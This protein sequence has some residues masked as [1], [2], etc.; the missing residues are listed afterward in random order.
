[1]KSQ[2]DIYR[3]SYQDSYPDIV[4][5]KEQIAAI[6]L[7]MEAMTDD[8]Y[9][10]ASSSKDSLENPLYEEL[11]KRQAEIDVD[12]MSLNR[13]LSSMEGM[14][15]SEYARS[16]RV[17]SHEADMSE[18]VRDYDV[19]REIYEEMLG[20]KEKAR[21][22]MTLDLEGQGVSFKI[23]E[24]AVYPL[25]PS[26]LRFIHFALAGPLAGLVAVLGLVAAYILL[27]PRVRSPILM[28]Q[29]LPA[30]IE[31]LATIP[32]INSSVVDRFKRSDMIILVVGFLLVGAAYA[33][34]TVSRLLGVL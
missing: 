16:E 24:P 28:V 14:L 30:N 15:K 1:M 11:R 23:Q 19:T 22:S 3:L 26:G 8:G 21:L 13:R 12:L 25:E 18:L 2:L 20:R 17:A 33:A 6:E 31:L 9:F 32:H 7:V 27:D 34:L 4:A 10:S 29:N 5:I